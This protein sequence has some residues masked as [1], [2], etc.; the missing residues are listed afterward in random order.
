MFESKRVRGA[1]ILG[2]VAVFVV[3]D[4]IL[5]ARDQRA[6]DKDI[7]SVER[8]AATLTYNDAQTAYPSMIRGGRGLGAPFDRKRVP[9]LSEGRLDGKD[10]HLTFRTGHDR[11]CIDLVVT[12]TGHR[13]SHRGC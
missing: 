8:V 3:G 1:T 6:V 7:A 10:V 5:S 9:M 13:V 4:A 12:P 11:V 2:V